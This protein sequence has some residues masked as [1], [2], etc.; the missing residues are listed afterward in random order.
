MVYSNKLFCF[1]V[2]NTMSYSPN[3]SRNSQSQI[4]GHGSYLSF[5]QSLQQERVISTRNQQDGSHFNSQTS[6]NGTN[7]T[8]QLTREMTLE[9]VRES[10]THMNQDLT[11]EVIRDAV[12][13]A[14]IETIRESTRNPRDSIIEST[15]EYTR[16]NFRESIRD[17]N[18]EFGRELKREYSKEAIRE[19][20]SV[21][22]DLELLERDTK[23]SPQITQSSQGGNIQGNHSST[24]IGQSYQNLSSLPY[25]HP[26]PP[27]VKNG[28]GLLMSIPGP[29][30]LTTPP[31]PEPI[32]P[33][34]PN[35]I[36]QMIARDQNRL[37]NPQNLLNRVVYDC[38]DPSPISHNH[39]AADPKPYHIPH[40]GQCHLPPYYQP[41]SP[42]DNTLVFESRFESGNLR[43]AIQV[44]EFEYDLI[45][46]FDV[47]TRGHTQ[48]YYFSVTNATKGKKYKF[49]I[50]NLLKGDSLYNYGMRPLIYSDL[51]A[52][53]KGRGWFRDG[54]DICYYQNNIKRKNGFFYTFTFSIEF[55]NDN[56]V[57]YFAYCY[58]YTYSNL[59]NYLTNLEADPIRR[60]LF[61]RR[62]LCHTLAGNSCDILTITSFSSDP[63]AMQRRKGVVVSARVHPGESNASWKM[64]GLID[65]LTGPQLDAKIL[66]DNFVFKIVPM[67]NPD[68]VINGNY[69][70]SLAG[71]DL[72]RRWIEPSKKLHP[73]I[74]HTKQMIKQFMKEREVILYCDFHGH[75]RKKNIFMY[76][77][78]KSKKGSSVQSKLSTR[79]FP[80]ILWKISQN[81]SYNDCSFAIQK[82]KEST[83]RVVVFKELGLLNSYTIEAS[84]CGASF[85]RNC[86]KHFNTRHL[87]QMGHFF[88]EA[89]LDY[90][91]PDQSRVQQV[92]KE[93]EVLYPEESQADNDERDSIGS[94][95]ESD[96]T[97]SETGSKKKKKKKNKSKSKRANSTASKKKPQQVAVSLQDEQKLV[98]PLQNK[99]EPVVNAQNI[100]RKEIKKM[101][102]N[103]RKAQ[104]EYQLLE[105][106]KIKKSKKAPPSRSSSK[107]RGRNLPSN[108][109]EDNTSD[110]Y[111]IENYKNFRNRLFGMESLS[112]RIKSSDGF[113][114]DYENNSRS[115]D[116]LPKLGFG[117]LR[118]RN[119]NVVVVDDH[120]GRRRQ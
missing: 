30:H 60:K 17:Q 73:S 94:D 42:T 5:E 52:K 1:D 38:I 9:S 119:N 35:L 79:V 89:I 117:R 43:R 93:L 36:S 114:S 7:S 107:I 88:C 85:G 44:Y 65:F 81:F 26:H 53:R 57:Y 4:Q 39:T 51:D 104:D 82:S 101:L 106:K 78:T 55:Q 67:L 66:R 76:G 97:D 2:Q 54:F 83:A 32:L 21:R 109:Q 12:R 6:S 110:D 14:A 111:E 41:L 56:D 48:W 99:Q 45:L 115:S 61:K 11:R 29:L 112:A 23:D 25:T 116:N 3:P 103:V 15:K 31:P 77:C 108:N 64:K 19:Q 16:E 24:N 59:Q 10:T 120:T 105:K 92:L 86:D 75:S 74:Y 37:Q 34:N 91:D 63:Q 87:E 62:T 84:F 96:S 100:S 90:C 72:N 102:A 68:G 49:N 80:R 70:S 20:R 113:D 50:I 118:S 98:Q 58:P 69:R 13:E 33:Q 8:I 18:K 47:N 46:K 22:E 40:V 71:V 27:I 95:D 28:T